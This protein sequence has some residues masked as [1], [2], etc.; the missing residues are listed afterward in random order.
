MEIGSISPGFLLLVFL[1]KS[2]F[3]ELNSVKQGHDKACM[4]YNC[5]TTKMYPKK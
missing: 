5:Y 3:V 4:S 2:N 1:R